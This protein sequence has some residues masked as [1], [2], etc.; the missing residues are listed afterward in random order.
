MCQRHASEFVESQ[1]QREKEFDVN[2]Q[3]KEREFIRDRKTM[4]ILF[5]EA[6]NSMEERFS[7]VMEDHLSTARKDEMDRETLRLFASMEFSVQTQFMEMLNGWKCEFSAAEA[8]GRKGESAFVKNRDEQKTEPG[9]GVTC[10]TKEVMESFP[11]RLFNVV[12]ESNWRY[13]TY[14]PRKRF[15]PT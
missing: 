3:R 14:R 15:A 7:Q 4:E 6:H 13:V 10:S 11:Y 2:E 5:K 1:Q 12:G 9:S 8:A